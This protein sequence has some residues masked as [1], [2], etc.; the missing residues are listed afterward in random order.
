MALLGCCEMLFFAEKKGAERGEI[1]K[2]VRADFKLQQLCPVSWLP[3]PDLDLMLGLPGL[4]LELSH[5]YG[6]TGCVSG[7]S[8]DLPP[9]IL[10][11]ACL[12]ITMAA[13]PSWS[14]WPSLHP[15]ALESICSCSLS[16]G[17]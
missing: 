3:D 17:P 15:L 7:L 12:A 5:G 16:K 2:N 1:N 9:G 8:P 14:H 6:L 4:T 11:P 10:T 13:P